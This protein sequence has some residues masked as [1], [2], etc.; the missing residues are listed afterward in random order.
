MSENQFTRPIAIALAL[1]ILACCS[2]YI[3][4]SLNPET[5]NFFMNFFKDAKFGEIMNE[6]PVILAMNL[7]V[8]NI[9]ACIIMFFGGVVLGIGSFCVLGLNGLLIGA[10]LEVARQT[11]GLLFVV[12]AILPHGIFEIP[13]FV[14]AGAFGI[15]LGEAVIREYLGEGD[16]G[17]TAWF[18]MKKFV[19][20]II[21]LIFV[22]AVMEAFV[23]P[24]FIHMVEMRSV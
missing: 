1:F 22:A 16:S 23:T 13:A 3:V 21:P 6:N 11:K 7:F 20:Y 14:L 17:E 18:L 8:N 19:I 9:E 10:I 5:G 12:A 2:G 24:E 4:S 15:M